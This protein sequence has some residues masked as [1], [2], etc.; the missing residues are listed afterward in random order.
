ME[1]FR[2]PAYG[3]L[4]PGFEPA[5]LKDLLRAFF[6]LSVRFVPE[7]AGSLHPEGR[8]GPFV[9]GQIAG[10]RHEPGREGGPL[11]RIKTVDIPIGPQKRLLGQILADLL[12][13]H[14]ILQIKE[15][16]PLVTKDEDLEGFRVSLSGLFDKEPVVHGRGFFP[17]H[18]IIP[19]EPAKVPGSLTP[20]QGRD[21]LFR[22]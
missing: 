12:G 2:K 5:L 15:D 18:S 4:D 3:L 21:I 20:A 8:F 10:Y 11:F 19:F 9:E 16:H 6:C 22:E 1:S 7:S 17:F 13:E 14:E